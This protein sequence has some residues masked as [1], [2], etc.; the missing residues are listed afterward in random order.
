MHTIKT[1][2]TKELLL[3]EECERTSTTPC[4]HHQILSKQLSVKNDI[5]L[6]ALSLNSELA[7]DKSSCGYS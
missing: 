4:C 3:A 2:A 6:T 1:L 5:K 7:V